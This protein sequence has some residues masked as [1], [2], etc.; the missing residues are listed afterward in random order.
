[1]AD[2]D[3]AAHD[4]SRAASASSTC[5]PTT[6]GSTR[7]PARGRTICA[8]GSR[9]SCRS[10]M[11]QHRLRI[12]RD[13]GRASR[14]TAAGGVFQLMLTTTKVAQLL[15]L[16]VRRSCSACPRSARTSTR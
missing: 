16:T 13:N 9:R 8:D 7:I 1:M 4:D 3:Q 6:T 14:Q 10:T 11:P 2:D 15:R 5:P 12:L